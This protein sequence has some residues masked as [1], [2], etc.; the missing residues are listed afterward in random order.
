MKKVLLGVVLALVLLGGG[1]FALV[2]MAVNEADKALEEEARNNAPSE[3]AVGKAFTHDD[4]AVA[5]GWK[6][7]KDA[8]GSAEVV[9]DVTN[10]ADAPRTMLLTIKVLDGDRVLAD[11]TCSTDELEP[12]QTTAIDC[13]SGDKLPRAYDAITVEDSI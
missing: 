2:G 13:L 12:G 5:A 3:V 11:I 7:R 10:K 8:L 4:W 1:C 6:L 9:G